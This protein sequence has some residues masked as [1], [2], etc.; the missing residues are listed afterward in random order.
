MSHP[1]LFHYSIIKPTLHPILFQNTHNF[2][3][4]L[5]LHTIQSNQKF[6]TIPTVLGFLPNLVQPHLYTFKR[7]V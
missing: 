3:T 2:Y 5:K 4:L 1:T 7:Q 6:H